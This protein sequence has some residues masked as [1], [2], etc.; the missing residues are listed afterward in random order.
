M[1]GLVLGGLGVA[2]A[3]PAKYGVKVEIDKK[4]DFAR[5]RS[6]TW[7]TRYSAPDK[8]VDAH[9]VAAIE[10]ELAAAGVVKQTSGPGD[11]VVVYDAQRRTDV[12]LKAKPSPEGTLPTYSVGLLI[13]RMLDPADGRTLFRAELLRPISADRD[14]LAAEIDADVADIFSRYPGRS[15]TKR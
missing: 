4:T 12:D 1:L 9:V 15:S 3:A 14:A 10:R 13:V 11:V 8:M 7:S 5:V 2:S 6:Y